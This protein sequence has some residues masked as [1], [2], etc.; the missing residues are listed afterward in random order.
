[1]SEDA[2][3]ILSLD[4]ATNTG[5]ACDAPTPTGKPVSGHFTVDWD[6]GRAMGRAG[7][8]FL[9]ELRGICALMQPTILTYEAPLTEQAHGMH[10]GQLLLGLAFCAGIIAFEFKIKECWPVDVNVARKH[11][12]G[13]RWA[14]KP[15]VIQ[16]C[17]VLGWD[18]KTHDEAD[19]M[20]LWDYSHACYRS[21][22][23]LAVAKGKSAWPT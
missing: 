6:N 12:V 9:R 2:D 1:M 14:K 21:G 16:R 13:T 20:C 5:W 22:A 4:I 17:N 7:F 18:P 8:K 15:D 10:A 11:F 3:R 23:I 19:A